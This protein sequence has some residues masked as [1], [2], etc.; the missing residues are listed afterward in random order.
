MI[1]VTGDCHGKFEKLS[2]ESFPEQRSMDKKDF[3][4]ITGDFGGVWSK[5]REDE[6]EKQKLDFLEARPFTTLFVDGNHENFDRLDAYPIETW[7]GGKVQRV[8]PSVIHLMRGQIFTIDGVS[9]FTFGGATS[10]D[11]ILRVDHLS[12]WARELPSQEEMDE[13]LRNL[14]AHHNK[15]DVIVTHCCSTGTQIL[16]GGIGYKLDYLTD[17]FE[18]IRQTVFFKRWYFGHYHAN[19]KISYQEIVLY[20]T[21]IKIK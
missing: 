1:Y 19:V 12:W 20:Q 8:R 18:K 15:V 14:E 4:I 6:A 9:F 2:E 3:V 21:I 13:G 7:H 11:K 10:P 5:D 16:I 17:Y